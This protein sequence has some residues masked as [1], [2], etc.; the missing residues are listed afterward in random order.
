LG[1]GPEVLVGI[2]MERSLEMVVGLLGIL[3]AGGAYVPLD[4]AYPKERLAF[5]L[6]DTQAPVLLTQHRL[7]TDLPIQNPKSEIQK[8]VVVCLDT[9]WEAIAR[10]SE[11]NPASGVTSDN[12]AYVIYTSGS[13]GRPKGVLVSHYNVVRLFQATHPWFHFDERDVWTLFHSYAFDFSVWELWGA[14]LSGGRL[15]VVPYWVSRSPEAFYDLLYK[16]Q[17]TV[18]NQTPSAFYQLIRA[19]ES[20]ATA[21][22]LTLRLVIFGGEALELQ[23]LKV[24]FDRHVDQ[25]TRLVNM[26]GI[27]ETTVHVT[28]R[29]LTAADL[30]M[31]SGSVIG[32]PIPDLQVYVLDQ[33]LQ[34]VP[35]GIPGELHIGGD[36][37]ARGY[38]N[39]PELTR[40][41]FIPHPFSD[42]P[43][44][45]LYKTGDLAR[46]LPD[47]N[48]E[49]LGRLDHQVKIRGFRIELGEIEAV[50]G[51]HPAVRETVVLAREEAEDPKSEIQNPKSAATRLVAYVVPRPA[52]TLSINE[53]RN[54]LKEKLPDYMVPSAFVF[55][56]LLPLT[57][58]GKVDR[59]A[60]PP[61]EQG[62][63][64]LGKIYVAPR[65]PTEELLVAIWAELLKLDKVGVHDNF[66]DLGGHS[67]LATQ[68][69]SRVLNAF[70]TKISLRAMFEKPTIE[71]L[72]V[73]INRSQP[74]G[75]EQENLSRMLADLEVISDEEARKRLADEETKEA[76]EK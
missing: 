31:V 75:G 62:R 32:R 29:P 50:L 22:D 58:N 6:E 73:V 44:A 23:S 1:V 3:K 49:F 12:L 43:G 30:S 16:E 34:S 67:L 64:E 48:I 72:A 51:Q 53:L 70:R 25:S 61:P 46:Y 28:Y 42:E 15:V 24:W 33:H 13:T 35:I 5:M 9:D 39:C 7:M 17:V 74:K 40:E 45:R 56:D 55:L 52:Q 54:F 41:K 57:P 65:T 47:G 26:Y 27:T 69:M 63:P 76:S 4:P 18:L 8:P 21:K 10:E 38:L 36:G 66:F 60:L 68:V 14:L 20:S 11:E 71:E 59:K 37:L 2:F 19:E